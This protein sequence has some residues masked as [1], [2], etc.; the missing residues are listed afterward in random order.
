[1]VHFQKDYLYGIQQEA[2][3]LPILQNH[4][5]NTLERNKE[6]WGKF[7]FYN[8]KSIFELK[9]RTNKKNAYPTTLMTCNKVVSI[10]DKEL[11]FLFNFID[12]LAYIKYDPILFET[13]EKKNYSRI[14][15]SYDEKEYYFI[16]IQHLE[17]IIKYQ[18]TI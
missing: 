4:F 14:N 6:R 5:G 18:P 9:S 12:E 3:I 17:T 16:P 13:F 7:D 8:D 1:M 11:Y 2:K 15:Q 10:E